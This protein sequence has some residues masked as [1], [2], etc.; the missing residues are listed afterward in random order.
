MLK[1]VSDKPNSYFLFAMGRLAYHLKK[2]PAHLLRFIKPANLKN[3]LAAFETTEELRRGDWKGAR[4]ELDARFQANEE[5]KISDG[6]ARRKYEDYDQY[7]ANQT[8]KLTRIEQK[9]GKSNDGARQR[10]FD[11][12]AACKALK[13]RRNVLCLGARL[14]MEV[15]ALI[16]LGHVAV[17]IDLNTGTDNSYV[18]H[19]DFHDIVF[20][21][22]AFDAVYTNTIDHCL[23]PEKMIPE[24]RRILVDGGLF[25]LDIT[26]GYEEGYSVDVD[27]GALAWPNAEEFAQYIAGL[28][29]F[30]II[31]HDDLP[32]PPWTQALLIKRG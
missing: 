18:L 6:I 16:D 21:D 27:W 26:R 15:K 13:G 28:G 9:L 24:V 32:D 11:M 10:F 8:S 29:N 20:G 22:G 3:S 31:K 4:D 19:G 23:E 30:E 17:G 7:V 25:I 2:N 1:P 14:G 12:F 5:W